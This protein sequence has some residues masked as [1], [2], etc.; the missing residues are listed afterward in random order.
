[1]EKLLTYDGKKLMIDGV[2]LG[3][4]A[5]MYHL[6]I[7]LFFLFVNEWCSYWLQR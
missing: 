6:S 2:D 1:M 7:P 3:E 5:N 4:L